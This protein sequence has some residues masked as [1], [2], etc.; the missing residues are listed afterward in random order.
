MSNAIDIYNILL[1]MFPNAH[2]ELNYHNLYELTVAVMLSAQTTDKAVNIV[3]PTLFSHYPNI[4]SL[5]KAKTTDVECDIKRLGLY[6]NKAINLVNM[7]RMVEEKYNGEIPNTLESLK[8]LPGIG[9]KTAN[10]ILVEY[11]KIP[12][13]PVD[14]HIERVSKRLGLVEEKATTLETEQK[15]MKLF[16]PSS[17]HQVHHLLLFLG[18]YHCTSRNPKCSECKLAKYCKQYDKKTLN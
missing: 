11:F 6:H 5:S 16:S 3:T 18:R 9:Q 8:S 1:E 7:A 10:V 2:C 15:L 4:S 12:R 13:M 14:T 17:Y